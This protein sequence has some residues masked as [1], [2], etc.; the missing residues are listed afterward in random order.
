MQRPDA[1]DTGSSVE[2]KRLHWSAVF[3]K[4]AQPR[5]SL[6]TKREW[7]PPTELPDLRRVG[8]RRA[9]HRDQRRGIAR[10]SRLVLAVGRRLGL[11]HQPRLARGRR[12]PR[13]LRSDATSRQP[14]FRSRR[15]STRWLKD[16][17][18]AGVRFVT[19]N[20][21]YD[22]GWLAHRARRPMPPSSSLKRSAR[23]RR[24]ST[25]TSSNTASTRSASATV[26]PAK[27]PRCWRR[28]AR[29]PA[30]RSTRRQSRRNPTSGNCRR[31]FAAR[32]AKPIR[33]IRCCCTSCWSDHRSGRHARAYRLE[34]DLM[35]MTI[36]MRRRG[37]RIDQNAAEQARDRLL[38]NVT[39]RSRTFGPASA[40]WSAWTRSTVREWK[41]KTFDRY[42][43]VSPRNTPKGKPSFAAGKSGWMGA[44]NTGCRS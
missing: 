8:H 33:S 37:I 32:M 29:P 1:G 18:A 26:C 25:R 34:C 16:H 43:I 3:Y 31:R 39:P 17:I 15:R 19:L 27:T 28:R 36:A 4:I 21:V 42:G 40:R 7:R 12:D 38:A 24:W 10:R 23:W 11:R 35:P 9:R 2:K 20:G 22:W 13:D 44:T 5:Q 41:I 30:S 14:E 6:V